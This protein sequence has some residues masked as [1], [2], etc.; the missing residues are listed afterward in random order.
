LAIL[1]ALRARTCAC[2]QAAEGP[3]TGSPERLDIERLPMTI[4]VLGLGNILLSDEG[5]GVRVVEALQERYRIPDG[6]DVVD[7]GTSGMDMLDMIANRDHLIVID[8]VNTGEPPTTVL[9]L[10]GEAVPVFFRSKI[11]PHQLGLSD[12]LAALRLLEAEPAGI[13]LIGIVPAA[14]DLGLELSPTIA[15]KLDDLVGMVRAE[16]DT[17]GFPLAPGD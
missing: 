6:V 3:F 16:L 11:S 4:L 15:A 9:R 7:G 1:A 5:V 13:T 8:A 14:L 10:T 12:V 17:L 2:R